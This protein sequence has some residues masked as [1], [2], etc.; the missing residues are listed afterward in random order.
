[1]S[2]TAYSAIQRYIAGKTELS[3]ALAAARADAEEYRLNVPDEVSGQLLTSL[4]ASS[5]HP[6][7]AG[8]VAI[9]PAAGVVGLYLL[10]GLAD[11]TTVTCIDPEA[12]HQNRARQVFRDAGY[13]PSRGRFLPSRPADVLSRLASESYQLVYLD[14]APLDLP[15]LIKAAY[16][17]LTV[18][19]S[20]FI[21]DA[22]LDGTLA[23]DT[24]KDRDTEAARE[25]DALVDT[26]DN[27]I[28]TR[29]PL[30][31]GLTLVTRKA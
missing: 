22:L 20:L 1:M 16:P 29:L 10:A 28:V 11:K 23:D 15:T 14:A 19:G 13:S 12:D 18:G 4:T 25:A 24:R 3:E 6:N 8:A 31:A 27:A 30:G 2:D 9:T 5:V 17:L 26:L 7:S 21:I